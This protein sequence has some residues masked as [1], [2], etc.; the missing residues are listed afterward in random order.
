MAHLDDTSERKDRPDSLIGRVVGGNFR[1]E[2]LLGGGGMG[3]VYRAEQL[4]LGKAVAVK[5]LHRELMRDETV[6]KRFERKA[7]S[8]SR[9]DHPNLVQIIDYGHDRENDILF[10]AME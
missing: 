1:I 7:R 8:A 2:N 9:L 3:N 10:I 6:V 4:S 5:V